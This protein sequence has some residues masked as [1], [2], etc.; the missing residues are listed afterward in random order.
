MME[1]S[2]AEFDKAMKDVFSGIA[3]NTIVTG[4][5]YQKVMDKVASE[6]KKWNEDLFSPAG[7]GIIFRR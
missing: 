4:D 5:T 2:R 3:P 6:R 1:P 7:L